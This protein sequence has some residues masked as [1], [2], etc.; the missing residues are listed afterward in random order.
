ML[1]RFLKSSVTAT[2]TAHQPCFGFKLT[3]LDCEQKINL[4]KSHF[5]SLIPRISLC[6]IRNTDPSQI[7]QTFHI[8]SHFLVVILFLG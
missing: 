7:I 1:S 4:I 2:N 5:L 3:K 8:D 6:R